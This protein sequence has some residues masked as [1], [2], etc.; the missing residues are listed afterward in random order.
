MVQALTTTAPGGTPPVTATAPGAAP[1]QDPAALPLPPLRADLEL[2]PGPAAPDGSPTWLIHD[3]ARNRYFSIGVIAFY[4]LTHWGRGTPAAVREAVRE[5]SVHDPSVEQILEFFKFLQMNALILAEGDAAR[6]YLGRIA[7]G[8]RFKLSKLGHNYLF[9]RIPLVR[10]DRFLAATLPLVRWMGSAW[11]R[12]LVVAT[13]ALG[14]VLVIRQWDSFVTTFP[15]LFSWQGMAFFFVT[16]TAVKILHELGHGYVAK[17]HGCTVPTMGLAFMVLYPVLYTD[18]TAAWRLV[19][20]RHRLRIAYAGIVVELALAAIAT[21]LWSFVPDGPFRTALF[22]T[23]TVTWISTLLVN[24][25]PF[26]R[27]DGYYLLGDATGVQN[28]QPRGFALGRWW[29]RKTV[30]G[31]RDPA[32]EELPAR[33]RAWMIAYAYA[34]WIYRFFLFLGIALLVYHFFIK[35]I[36]I[37]LMVVELYYFIAKPILRE[38]KVWVDRRHDIG[39]TPNLIGSVAV[40]AV[41]A[42]L[43][44][45]PWNTRITVP[46]VM[47]AQEY[48]TLFPPQAARLVDVRVAEGDAVTRG[49]V[50]FSLTAPDLAFELE[51]TG[52]EIALLQHQILR[53]SAGGQ[54]LDQ[55]R[56][57][58]QQLATALSRYR[59]TEALLAR[60]TVT[61]PMDGVVIDLG[62]D[63]HPGRWLS[64]ADAL[65]LVVE[66]GW[67]VIRGYAAA[68]DLPRMQ[69]GASARFVPDDPGRPVVAATVTT[70]ETVNAA[71]LTVPM[72]ASTVGGPIPVREDA[73]GALVP[74]QA[75]YRVTLEPE[76]GPEAPDQVIRGQVHID[77]AARSVADRVWRAVAAVLIRESGF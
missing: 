59:G 6:S 5:T 63:L 74:E 2:L 60:L 29:L 23:A 27:F 28:L 67:T 17:A 70:V 66:P 52:Q 36:G 1:D 51:S 39:V 50:L 3:Q 49:Q 69:D 35:A 53:R 9:F 10:P 26:M 72:L 46:A 16:L 21:L 19:R 40:L 41:L 32:P 8:A 77:G 56:V 37:L 18:T 43:A 71:R 33:M 11:F 24:L 62:S 65:A 13:G 12:W 34:T 42:G 30:L 75:I 25:N 38:L 57:L 44:F 76:T 22:M 61:A 7:E 45:V 48:T 31:A 58:E 73:E 15:Y 14:L 64:V 4:L 54:A 55:V 68:E 20:R 47:E